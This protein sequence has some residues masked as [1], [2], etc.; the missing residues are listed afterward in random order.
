M[1]EFIWHQKKATLTFRQ[2]DEWNGSPKGTVFRRF[3]TA[4]GQLL[5]GRDFFRIDGHAARA[6]VDDLRQQGRLYPSSVHAILLT[7]S[8]YRQLMRRDL[9]NHQSGREEEGLRP[10]PFFPEA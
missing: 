4:L 3:K 10:I 9:A 7:A 1:P 6:Q 5:E 2:L 8:G